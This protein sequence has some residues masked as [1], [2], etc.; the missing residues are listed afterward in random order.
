MFLISTVIMAV[1]MAGLVGFLILRLKR[2]RARLSSEQGSTPKLSILMILAVCFIML[3]MVLAWFALDQVKKKIQSDVGSALQI[4]LQTTQES[5]NLWIET[6]KF[7]LSLL[8]EEPRLVSL[9]ERHLRVPR[10]KTKLSKSDTLKELRVFFKY[11]RSQFG[12]AGFFIISPDGGN[13]YKYT[14]AAHMVGRPF[15]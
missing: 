2:S 6:N 3:V 10:N 12:Q 15:D 4:V 5:L 13:T 11:R 7:Q 14:R 8:A 9:V 1:M